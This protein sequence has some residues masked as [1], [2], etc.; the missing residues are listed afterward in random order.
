MFLAGFALL[1]WFASARL[2]AKR[3]RD[4]REPDDGEGRSGRCDP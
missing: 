2:K 1:G 3:G 4:W